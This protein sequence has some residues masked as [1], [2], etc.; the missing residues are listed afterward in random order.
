MTGGI[1]KQE[2][3][4]HGGA[5][6]GWNKKCN[7]DGCVDGIVQIS[8]G[9]AREFD[10]ACVG[11]SGS[12]HTI[13]YANSRAWKRCILASTKGFVI[14]AGLRGGLALFAVLTRLKRKSQVRLKG[15]VLEKSNKQAIIAALKETLRYGMFLGTYAGTFTTLDEAI[16]AIGG[17][18]RT[19]RWRSLAAGAIASPSL[20]LTGHD[21]RH[22]SMAIYILI[23]AAVLAAR[24]GIKSKRLG[25]LCR[26]LEWKYGDVFLMCLSSSQ[27][28]SAWILKPDSLPSS[29]I[30]FL[31]KHGGKDKC[32]VEGI[33]KLAFREGSKFSVESIEQFYKSQGVQIQLDPA[34]KV[35]C[36]IIHGNEQCLMHFL[37]FL[38]QAYLR[39]L[40]VYLPVY[41]APAL[42][43][44][45][46]GLFRRPLT[47]L[48]KTLIG[49][50]RSSLFLATYCASAWIWSCIIFR[51]AGTCSP[52]LLATATF[53]TGLTLMIEKKSRQME[54]ALYCLSRAIESSAICIADSG[55]LHQYDIHVPNRIDVVLFSFATAIIMH[56]YSQEREVFRS[57]YLNVLD[58]VFGV[59]NSTSEG[60]KAKSI[61]DREI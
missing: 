20:M 7:G 40:P 17:V 25:W 9:A 1:E 53:P 37:V 31:N 4:M 61:H 46:Q 48:A 60:I 30:S 15:G 45:R 58:W 47:I 13:E 2:G 57:K 6:D 16:A 10:D 51:T 32:I 56:C 22:T 49:T 38:G 34:M 50:A 3:L 43:V 39:S 28:L 44:H 21:T 23:R 27:I 11:A 55:C 29:Y 24:C 33:R 41:L 14:G 18:Q 8:E 52:A 35:P 12:D 36:T 19:A 59:P 54:I 42:V 5:G 26:P